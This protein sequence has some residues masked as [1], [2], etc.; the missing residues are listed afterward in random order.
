[1]GN[2]F[3]KVALKHTKCG[4]NVQSK[5]S[6]RINEDIGA[7][8]ACQNP[9]GFYIIKGFQLNCSGLTS[10]DASRSTLGIERAVSGTALRMCGFY[11]SWLA[12]V[13]TP[14]TLRRFFSYGKINNWLSLRFNRLQLG[15]LR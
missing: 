14:L 13:A 2:A 3:H 11:V 4:L 1:M 12:A 10:F 5:V 9:S 15:T 8:F 7:T 6:R